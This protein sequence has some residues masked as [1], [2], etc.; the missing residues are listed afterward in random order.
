MV[1]ISINHA[2]KC[3][4]AYK[5]GTAAVI[6]LPENGTGRIFLYRADGEDMWSDRY[7]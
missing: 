3:D 7:E 5:S 2:G 4:P 6:F 1:L